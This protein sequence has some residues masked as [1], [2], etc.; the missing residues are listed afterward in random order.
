MRVADLPPFIE[1]SP[2][3]APTASV[4]SSPHS[5]RTYP[6]EFQRQSRLCTYDLRGSED[7]YVDR[8]F[9]SAPDYGA[10]LLCGSAPRSYLDLN[11]APDELGADIVDGVDAD[12]PTPRS[13]AGYGVVPSRVGA[14]LKIYDG[15]LTLAEIGARLG[16]FHVPF[17]DRITEL[18][19]EKLGAFGE[20]IL[21]DCHSMP[22]RA[23]KTAASIGG[24]APEVLLG[25]RFGQ[26]A[27]GGL[28]EFVEAAFAS[29]GL[30]VTRNGPFPGGYISQRHGR[31]EAGCHVIQIEINRS[32]Y[33]D[34]RTLRPLSGFLS[35]R[36]QLRPVVSELSRLRTIRHQI[37]AE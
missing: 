31:P 26:A 19:N 6:I 10:S 30:S 34:E 22:H 1:F 14:G 28:V 7:A 17:H 2:R 29:T 32:L 9:D 27:D 24:A 13:K 8:L 11:R 16:S 4:F 37:A 36:E 18:M 21:F 25:D 3:T 12:G 15:K 35:F 23:A 20:A 5:G 33:M